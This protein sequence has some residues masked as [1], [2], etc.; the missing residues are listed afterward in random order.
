MHKLRKTSVLRLCLACALVYGFGFW[1]VAPGSALAR[2]Q[3]VSEYAVTRIEL[4]GDLKRRS[5]EISGLTWF[6]DNLIVLPQYP[7]FAGGGSFLYAI[8]KDTLDNYLENSDALPVEAKKIRFDAGNLATTIDGYEGFEAIQFV[9]NK[10]YLSIE[11]NTVKG[12]RS[13]LVSGVIADDLSLIKLDTDSLVELVPPIDLRNQ[14]YEALLAVEDEIVVI[15]EANGVIGNKGSEAYSFDYDLNYVGR[16]SMS[17]LP[18]RLTDSTLV[19]EASGTFWVINYFYP[20]DKDLDSGSD[21]VSNNYGKGKTHA[22]NEQVERLLQLK[23]SSNDIVW[24]ERPPVQ[25]E[26]SGDVARNWEGLA[27][28]DNR[29]FIVATDK[30][31]ETILAF[32]KVD[33]E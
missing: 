19:D 21:F 31:P 16:M 2:A 27:K 20:G 28:L 3:D 23:Y 5:A 4:A 30:Y 18:Y 26:L 25:L 10:I 17:P 12:M 22:E 32:V 13:Y 33:L 11:A 8:T 9:G 14:S 29:G 24:T 1:V 15:F 7:G 6:A